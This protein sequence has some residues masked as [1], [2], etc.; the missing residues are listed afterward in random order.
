MHYFLL[1][2]PRDAMLSS[3]VSCVHPSVC[4]KS[5]VLL[6]WLNLESCKQRC[7]IAQ[8][9][10]V[11]RCHPLSNTKI[12]TNIRTSPQPKEPTNKS[13]ITINKKSTT[14]FPTSH[15]WT[16]YVTPK[17]PKGGTQRDFAIFPVNFNL[18][19][20]RLLQ[21]FFVWKLPVENC[22]CIIPLSK[23]PYGLR[24]TSTFT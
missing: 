2:L 8:G 9:H 12:L 5:G 7:T 15:R 22:S 10:L 18:C 4:H 3:C 24:A 1:I 23:G 13:S 14:R 6:R 21:S 20:K 16:V 17:S 11:C 19:R